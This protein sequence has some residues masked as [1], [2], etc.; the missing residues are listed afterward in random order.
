M[1]S[2]T[3]EEAKRQ[4]IQEMESQARLEAA[5]LA[6]RMLEEAKENAD[7]EAREIISLFHSARDARL[8]E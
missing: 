7:R 6:K 2:L 5:G 1:A 3:A 4:L 8:C